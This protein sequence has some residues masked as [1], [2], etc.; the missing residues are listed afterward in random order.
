[1]V[2]WTINPDWAGSST[3]FNEMKESLHIGDYKT[4]NLYI[5]N[6][7]VDN[8]GGT[9]TH[10]WRMQRDYPTDKER[11]LILDGCVVNTLSLP[12]SSHPFM[13]QGKTAVH[14]IGHWLGL[15]HPWEA[16]DI[17]NGVNPPNPCWEGNPDDGVA[18]TPKMRSMREGTCNRTANTCPE[19][20][21]MEPIYDPVT[22]IMGYGS[23]ECMEILFTEG[24][25]A[26]MYEYYDIYR[27]TGVPI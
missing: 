13:N 27:K 19:P 11:R 25:V 10:P 22:N 16:G 5:R 24:Q 2:R 23:D 18:D 3:S 8:Y 9:C 6:I 26:R 21:G 12:G 15:W 14:E 17:R 4:L 7:T 20:A 1:M